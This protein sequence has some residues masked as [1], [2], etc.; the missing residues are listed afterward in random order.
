MSESLKERVRN[1]LIRQL[2]EDGPPD[3]ERQD[4]RQVS[5]QN[6]L[7]LLEAVSEDDPF[8]EELAARYMVP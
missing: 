7:D 3:P 5:V 4:T 8:V 2:D 1:K 6:D